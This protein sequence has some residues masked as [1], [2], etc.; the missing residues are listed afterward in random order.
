MNYANWQGEIDGR[1]TD[2]PGTYS[3]PCQF[4]NCMIKISGQG[5]T[6]ASFVNSTTTATD[7]LGVSPSYPQ[8]QWGIDFVP[9]GN[10]MWI[11]DK[12]PR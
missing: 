11:W 3:D 10:S 12:Y 8:E 1:E 6:G 7:T 5:V 9:N 4:D 2:M